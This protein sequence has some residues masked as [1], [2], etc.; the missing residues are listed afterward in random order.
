[1][2]VCLFVHTRAV[3]ALVSGGHMT[4]A[5]VVAAEAQCLAMLGGKASVDVPDEDC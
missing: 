5:V 2:T 4:L 1:M 3:A